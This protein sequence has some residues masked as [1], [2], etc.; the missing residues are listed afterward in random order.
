MSVGR[1]E[2]LRITRI[3]GINDGLSFAVAYR[4]T[5]GSWQQTQASYGW[6]AQGFV[7]CLNP[8]KGNAI[9]NELKKNRGLRG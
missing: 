1:K 7:I 4:L 3:T 8:A 5:A 6:I 9:Q 2:K